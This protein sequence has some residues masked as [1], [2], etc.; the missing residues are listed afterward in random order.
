MEK[1]NVKFETSM[2]GSENCTC[3]ACHDV[4]RVMKVTLPRTKFYDGKKL[5]AKYEQYWLCAPC[6]T[7]LTH[8]LDFPDEVQ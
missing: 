1:L 7:K 2:S 6:R 5:S 3:D 4:S 8:A